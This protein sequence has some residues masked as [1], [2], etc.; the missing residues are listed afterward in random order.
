[1]IFKSRL[2]LGPFMPRAVNCEM[3]ARMQQTN[4]A[5]FYDRLR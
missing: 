3:L 5:P 2:E 4:H 1:M